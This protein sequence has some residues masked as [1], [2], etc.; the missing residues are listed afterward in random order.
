MVRLGLLVRSSSIFLHCLRPCFS[1]T[2][3]QFASNTLL[4]LHQGLCG[5]VSPLIKV[6]DSSCSMYGEE[7]GSHLFGKRFENAEDVLQRLTL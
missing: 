5:D 2:H 6:A 4:V 7:G 3:W 1:T